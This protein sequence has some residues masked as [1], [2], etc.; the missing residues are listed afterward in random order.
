M[1]G[2]SPQA[3]GRAP[4]PSGTTLALKQALHTQY[5]QAQAETID[6]A[7]AMLERP[8]GAIQQA[9]A[10]RL[11]HAVAGL[12][13]ATDEAIATAALGQPSDYTLLLELLTA[14]AVVE[15]V[16]EEDPLGPARLR[17]LRDRERLLAAEGGS[18][19]ATTAME[20]LGLKS[21]QAVQQRRA[22]GKL[23][24][25]PLGGS[26]YRYPI[27]Q[28]DQH[29]EVLPGFA[30][31]LTAL[32][33]LDPWGQAA[34]LLAGEPRLDGMRPL[35]ALRAGRVADVMEAARHYGEQGGG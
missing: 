20:I 9:L 3:Q 22:R 23:L 1:S 25:L 30:E 12:A 7:L 29:G 28:F 11:F 13:A 14:P 26:T 27:W 6:A 32:V 17:W 5:P 35:D 31:V 19:P 33:H 34:Y 18:V 21:R 24:G 4:A 2:A 15:R 10:A 8:T 16:R